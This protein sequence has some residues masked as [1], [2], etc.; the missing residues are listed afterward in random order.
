MNCQSS[1]SSEQREE[2]LIHLVPKIDYTIVCDCGG[3][4][5][6]K[7]QLRWIGKKGMIVCFLER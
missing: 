5:D 4:T 3:L 1:T 2:C 6:L 7:Y